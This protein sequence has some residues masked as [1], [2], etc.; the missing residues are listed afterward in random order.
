MWCICVQSEVKLHHVEN[1]WK[2]SWEEK[3][4]VEDKRTKTEDVLGKFRGMLSKMPPQNFQELVQQVLQLDIHT[5]NKL[6]AVT[7]IIFEEVAVCRCWGIFLMGHQPYHS[8]AIK[9]CKF[10]MSECRTGK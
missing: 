5:E 3:V 9:C 2:P 6:K 4:E 8:S 7:N 10:I 1:A